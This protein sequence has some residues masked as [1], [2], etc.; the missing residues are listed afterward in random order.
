MVPSLTFENYRK[1]VYNEIYDS[2]ADSLATRRKRFMGALG[3]YANFRELG[4]LLV[5]CNINQNHWVLLVADIWRGRLCVC[6]SLHGA[7]SRDSHGSLLELFDSFVKEAHRSAGATPPRLVKHLVRYGPQPNAHDCGVY[8]C[9]MAEHYVRCGSD[10][11]FRLPVDSLQACRRMLRLKL[12]EVMEEM[13][14]DPRSHRSDCSAPAL[15]GLDG[16][17]F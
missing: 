13:R 17:R 4:I 7:S 5:P 10:S 12:G 3:R 8:T 15:L 1:W 9:L 6:D 2:D 11:G 16:P 14:R